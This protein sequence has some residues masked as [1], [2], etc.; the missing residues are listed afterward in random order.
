MRD[1]L[2]VSMRNGMRKHYAPLI[3]ER[4]QLLAALPLDVPGVMKSTTLIDSIMPPRHVVH[5][6]QQLESP[7]VSTLSQ[8][9]GPLQLFIISCTVIGFIPGGPFVGFAL[10]SSIQFYNLYTK[11]TVATDELPGL[12]SP[13]ISAAP[14]EI[15]QPVS[16]AF[17][18][19]SDILQIATKNE[20]L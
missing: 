13:A 10:L 7:N 20:F 16:A 11:A 1:A 12:V 4:E 17:S 5:N 9:E 15:S 19:A 8:T 6:H 2:E 14:V 3:I 18:G